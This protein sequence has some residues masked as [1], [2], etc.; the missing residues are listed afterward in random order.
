M[1]FK[2][3][4]PKN[5]QTNI[6]PRVDVNTNNKNSVIASFDGMI[7]QPSSYSHNYHNELN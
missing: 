2:S 3:L 1:V 7:V 4:A 5:K 6:P